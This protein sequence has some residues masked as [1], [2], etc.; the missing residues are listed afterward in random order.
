MLHTYMSD[1]Y[2]HPMSNVRKQKG[3]GRVKC[4]I[5]NFAVKGNTSKN[6]GKEIPVSGHFRPHLQTWAKSKRELNVR[7]KKK[8]TRHT[9]TL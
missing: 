8:M 9:V 7:K 4:V 1:V 2:Y 5:L 3:V 6:Y